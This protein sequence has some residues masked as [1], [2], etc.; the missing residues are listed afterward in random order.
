MENLCNRKPFLLWR[1]ALDVN[2]YKCG[3]WTEIPNLQDMVHGLC[4]RPAFAQQCILLGISLQNVI[5]ICLSTQLDACR[6][7]YGSVPFLDHVDIEVNEGLEVKV[8]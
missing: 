4:K 5:L 6:N 1:I 3:P 8:E 2:K 7:L